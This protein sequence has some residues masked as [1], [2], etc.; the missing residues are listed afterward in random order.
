MTVF[1]LWGIWRDR[2]KGKL[3][4]KQIDEACTNSQFAREMKMYGTFYAVHGK[5]DVGPVYLTPVGWDE[6]IKNV[7]S[8]KVV[9]DGDSK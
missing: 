7:V 9:Y 6:T 3:T 1:V 2:P 8:I 4:A 5:D